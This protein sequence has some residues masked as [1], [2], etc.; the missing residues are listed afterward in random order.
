[1]S[2]ST[3]EELNRTERDKV[4][5]AYERNGFRSIMEHDIEGIEDHLAPRFNLLYK[6]ENKKNYFIFVSVQRG[7]PCHEI[8]DISSQMLV[9]PR[10]GDVKMVARKQFFDASDDIGNIVHIEMDGVT[11]PIEIL[12]QILMFKK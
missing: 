4:L 8:T 3:V 12:N 11:E 2:R 5:G 10:H 6:Y 9:V 7:F 1:M